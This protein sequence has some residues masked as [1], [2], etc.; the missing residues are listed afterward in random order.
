MYSQKT[1]TELHKAFDSLNKH[2]YG[3][4]L[5][6]VAIVPLSTF[7]K[8]AYGW[9]TPDKV[10]VDKEGQNKLHEIAIGAE[11]L[12]RPYLEVIET[13]HH[14]MIHLY[15]HLKEIKDTVKKGKYHTDK[16]KSECLA[17]GFHYEMTEPNTKFGWAWPKLTDE[18]MEIVKGFGLDESAFE[19]ARAVSQK[20]KKTKETF[21]YMCPACETKV[22][23]KKELNIK[24]NDCD[25]D[26]ILY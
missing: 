11:Y 20:K 2:F 1:V 5:P 25:E 24:C 16:F 19:L 4:N 26:F 10:W 18:T 8:Q 14:E 17:R 21:K 3:G 7:K 6:E 13:L 22:R 12:N 23:V 9:F 15:C